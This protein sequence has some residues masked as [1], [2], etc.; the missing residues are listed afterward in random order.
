M[1]Y[2]QHMYNVGIYKI[3]FVRIFLSSVSVCANAFLY[4]PTMYLYCIYPAISKHTKTCQTLR[5][6]TRY[7]VVLIVFNGV[8]CDFNFY[9]VTVSYSCTVRITYQKKTIDWFMM[10]I[11]M[12]SKNWS[13]Q[14]NL[15]ARIKQGQDNCFTMVPSVLIERNK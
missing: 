6:K 15:T 5:K 2:R 14:C 7:K 13:S 10:T 9:T 3:S 11:F 1:I 4:I 12:H 8:Q